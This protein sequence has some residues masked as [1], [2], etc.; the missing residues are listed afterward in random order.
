MEEKDKV[1]G[2]TALAIVLII[3]LVLGGIFYYIFSNK[4][5][6]N[7]VNEVKNEEIKNEEIKN[8]VNELAE[9]SFTL[10]KE[11]Y[12]K[13]DGATAMKPMSVEIAKKVLG[14]TQEEAEKFI[15]HNTTGEA[16]QNLID[17][18]TDL[19]FVSEPSDDILNNAKKAGVEFEMVGI[20]RD[21]FVFVVNK[22]NKISS[23]TIDEIQKIYTGKITNWKEV[24]GEDCEII[25]YQR[26]ANSGSQ[27]LMEKM[28]MKDLKM[29]EVPQSLTIH[30][31]RGLIDCVASYENSKASL[32]Y[33]I[34]LYAKEQY[35]KD[36]IKFLA[37]NGVYPTDETIADGSYPLSKIVYAIYRKDEPKDS[38]V[39][40]LV[41][42]LKTPEGQKAVEAGGYVGLK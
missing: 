6:N 27:N 11:N 10:T 12:P 29:I 23:L 18:K 3:L 25:A 5:K 26:E 37:I 17:K 19:I 13:V 28:V 31:M 15:V 14:M 41:E 36:S 16:Y 20:G 8:E 1:S 34:Y 7:E 42:W 35:V 24:G 38:N 22:E 40:K 33:S 32:G 2:T 9:K 21:G 30:D 39:R 4:E